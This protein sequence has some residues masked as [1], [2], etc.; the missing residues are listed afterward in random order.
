[1]I[2]AEEALRKI[3]ESLGNE[4]QDKATVWRVLHGVE[5]RNKSPNFP[6]PTQEQLENLRGL[7]DEQLHE[8]YL[9]QCG[10][11][12]QLLFMY[13]SASGEKRSTVHQE[14]MDAL[15]VQRDIGQEQLER[16][17]SSS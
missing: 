16:R 11:L 8:S 13:E 7:T 12:E 15:K 2:R 3:F 1:M 6:P 9:G 5:Y 10:Y 14:I 4:D 17:E